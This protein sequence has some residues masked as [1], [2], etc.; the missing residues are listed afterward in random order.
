MTMLILHGFLF[1][2]HLCSSTFL[3]HCFTPVL[4]SSTSLCLGHSISSPSSDLSFRPQPVIPSRSQLT[5]LPLAPVWISWL[6]ASVYNS[7]CHTAGSPILPDHLPHCSRSPLP[8]ETSLSHIHGLTP[9]QHTINIG[10][11]N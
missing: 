10:G 8:S 7:S 4:C 11:E 2:R 3:P 5:P 6:C 1:I 9:K